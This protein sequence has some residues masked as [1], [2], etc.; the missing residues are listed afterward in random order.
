MALYQEF[1][2]QTKAKP[3]EKIRY[4]EVKD[5]PEI[6][7]LDELCHFPTMTEEELYNCVEGDSTTVTKVM[8]VENKIVGFHLYEMEPERI[9][10][11]RLGVGL[12]YRRMGYGSKFIKEAYRKLTIKRNELCCI[13][14]EHA[15]DTIKFMKSC[16]F[17]AVSVKRN[18]CF[19]DSDGYYF[20]M[21]LEESKK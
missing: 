12:E 8:E 15:D 16:G 5:I 11:L 4:L 6:L 20:R 2:C 19:D 3:K 17:K 14:C 7:N 18:E 13:V 1:T 9:Q 21:L 10:I